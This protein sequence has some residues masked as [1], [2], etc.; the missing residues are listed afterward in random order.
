MFESRPRHK[1]KGDTV[2]FIYLITNS[3]NN[4]KYIGKTL[5]EN[6]NI[7]FNEHI[8][9]SRRE[10]K[11]NRPLYSAI[12]KY[13]EDSFS[14]SVIEECTAEESSAREEFWINAYDTYQR[15]YNATLG[16]DGK[17]W[18]DHERLRGLLKD[19]VDTEAICTILNCCKATVWAEARA[20][21]LD[22]S[23]KSRAG[24]APY[25][26]PP[27]PVLMLT[28]DGK[29]LKSFRSAI[30]AGAY[31]GNRKKRDHILECAKGQRKT[32]YGYVWKFAE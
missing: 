16:G 15:G 25:A 26:S 2:A 18:V 6:V 30:A 20:L 28:K 10:T 22:R 13:G 9:E 8:R 21:G 24:I 19:D 27:T 5:H 7:R 29:L 14:V 23:H 17:P 4:K 32:A 11:K 12:R 31:L 3:A 1:I